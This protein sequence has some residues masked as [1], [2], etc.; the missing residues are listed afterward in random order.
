MATNKQKNKLFKTFKSEGKTYHLF[1]NKLHNWDGPAVYQSDDESIDAEY[2]LYGRQL[3][4]IEW[5]ERKNEVDKGYETHL[6]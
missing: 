4:K 3:N 1:D 5:T 6:K 2:H